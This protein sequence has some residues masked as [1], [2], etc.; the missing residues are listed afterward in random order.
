MKNIAFFLLITTGFLC[1]CK[2]LLQETPRDFITSSNF[3]RNGSDAQAAIT[4]AYSSLAASY[5]ITYWLFLVNHADYENGRGSQAPISNFGKVLDPANVLRTENIWASFYQNINISNSVLANVANINMDSQTKTRILAEAHFIRALSYFDLVRGFGA[6]PI[7]S[8]P[9]TNISSEKAHRAPVDSVYQFIINDALAAQNGLPES[10]GPQTGQASLWA[11]KMLLAEVYLTI[12]VWDSAAQE[13]DDIIN[14]GRYQLVRV[15]V[16]GDFYKIFAVQ[17]S[18]EDIFSI[19]YDQSMQSSLPNYLSRP[20]TPPYNYSGSGVFAWLPNMKSFLATW[21]GKDLRQSFNLYTKYIGPNG[22]SVSLPSTTPIL[23]GKFITDPQ[24]FSDYSAPIFRYAEAFLIYAEAACMANGGPT[25]MALERLNAIR[26]RAYGFDPT[27][28]SP[29]D[30]P[31]G[32]SRDAFRDT[33]LTERA[34]EFIV[35]GK[36]WW[37]LKRTGTAQQAME[38]VGRSF[39][40]ARLLWPIPQEEIE[41]NPAIP[42]QDQNPGY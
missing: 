14:S 5:G 41:N 37:D 32:M 30:Y 26:R 7:K 33:V 25:R 40:S 23:F 4:G 18:S 39:I 6:V 17:T 8:K 35:E 28:P 11:D 19:H 29:F 22:D 31:S 10:V 21:D 20:H 42:Q 38:A 9:S 16:P 2:K 36:R 15:S 12:G 24:G 1:S 27:A 13:A 3:Y 34:K